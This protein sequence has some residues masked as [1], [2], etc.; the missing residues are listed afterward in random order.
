MEANFFR[1]CC[2]CIC[3]T[4]LMNIESI[5]NIESRNWPLNRQIKN[6]CY[7]LALSSNL[8]AIKTIITNQ[9]LP[10]RLPSAIILLP[11]TSILIDGMIILA[12]KK[13]YFTSVADYIDQN[14]P[15][16]LTVIRRISSIATL[17]LLAPHVGKNGLYFF[18][19]AITLGMDVGLGSAKK[20]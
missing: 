17:F 4:S 3:M 9:P 5:I 8:I 14:F 6:L 7:T 20:N 2:D 1:T 13:N 15:T 18:A 11:V 12:K 10:S 19:A 16:W